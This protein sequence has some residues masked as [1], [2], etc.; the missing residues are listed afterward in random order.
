MWVQPGDLPSGYQPCQ[1]IEAI[2]LE[3][4]PIVLHRRALANCGRYATSKR[5]RSINLDRMYNNAIAHFNSKVFLPTGWIAWILGGIPVG[6]SKA[7][8]VLLVGMETNRR[9]TAFS[10]R[11]SRRADRMANAQIGR[12]GSS[13][14]VVDPQD[15]A[16]VHSNIATSTKSNK[17]TSPEK[18]VHE[19]F[20]RMSFNVPVHDQQMKYLKQKISNLQ[21]M[22]INYKELEWNISQKDKYN[23]L[24]MK[25]MDAQEKY[26]DLLDKAQQDLFKEDEVLHQDKDEAFEQDRDDLTTST[27]DPIKF[28]KQPINEEIVTKKDERT[29]STSLKTYVSA[30]ALDDCIRQQGIQL[31]KQ[32]YNRDGNYETNCEMLQCR[33]LHCKNEAYDQCCICV[34]NNSSSS[35][36]SYEFC[37]EHFYHCYHENDYLKP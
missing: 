8:K 22:L 31:Y 4:I 29:S 23:D 34:N 18:V 3:M 15:V 14:S 13:A 30:E 35:P 24:I 7:L 32:G 1:L 12:A 25:Q 26:N 16:T 11:A 20:L 36:R 28:V 10:S 17:E 37:V 6:E 33:V 9:S 2:R 21:E 27:F 5:E 19:H